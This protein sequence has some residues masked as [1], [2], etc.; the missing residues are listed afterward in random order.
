[1]WVYGGTKEALGANSVR[2]MQGVM[3]QLAALSTHLAT[4]AVSTTGSCFWVWL[5]IVL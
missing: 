5:V 2:E 1:V 4:L 3:Q